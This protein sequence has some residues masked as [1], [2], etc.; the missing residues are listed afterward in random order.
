MNR[1]LRRL[2]VAMAVMFLSLMI[3]TTYTQFVSADALNRDPRNVRGI[4]AEFNNA[5][6][7]IVVSG[8]PIV[9]S[10]PVDTPFGF[11]RVFS[12]GDPTRAAMYA[13]VTG[14]FSIVNGS[15]GIER[16]ANS[17]LSGRDDAMWVD[18]LINLLTG[19]PNQGASVELTIDERIQQAAWDALGGQRGAVVAI[20]PRTGA[21]L[22]MVSKPSYDPN[23]L[24]VHSTSVANQAY[25]DALAALDDPLINRTL[26]ALYPP[27][28]TFKLITAAAALEHAGMSNDTVIPAPRTF[29]LPGTNHALPNFGGVACSPTDEQSLLDAMRVS[30]NTAFAMLAVELGGDVMRQTA[31][32]FGFGE[33][34]QV[35]MRSV[36]SRF[37]GSDGFTGDRVALAGIGQG[38]VMTTPLQMALIAAAIAND[39]VI[40]QPYLIDTVRS[41]DLEVVQIANPRELRRAVSASTAHQLRDQMVATVA[42]G[43]GT[44]A[45]ISGVQVA[46]KTGTAQTAPGVAPHA[47]FTAF[48]PADDP[49][50]A[51]AIIVEH[52]GNLAEG[53]TGGRLAAPMARQIIQAALTR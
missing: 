35:P 39:G 48:A 8:T 44:A 4:F 29:T 25:Q 21:I 31:E 22:A 17:F 32:A 24:A 13:P 15:T 27:G 40:M 19:R 12:G 34:F 47:W 52:G 45:Q 20:D 38:D 43:T 36:I 7:P 37:P 2:S 53:A 11:Q 10:T 23:L 14:F 5:R 33:Q 50:I 49:Q 1:T 42:T 26:A 16:A 3:A 18:R 6:G 46:G 9:E 30:C 51:L 28:S 41:A